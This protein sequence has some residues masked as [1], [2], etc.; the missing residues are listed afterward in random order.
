[1]L[2]LERNQ[3]LITDL[4]EHKST[5]F[6]LCNDRQLS[7]IRL[8]KTSV[9]RQLDHPDFW[10]LRPSN[11]WVSTLIAR[12]WW[13]YLWTK[14]KNFSLANIW[15]LMRTTGMEYF[16]MRGSWENPDPWSQH[17]E[18]STQSLSIWG[19]GYQQRACCL[20]VHF[21]TTQYFVITPWTHLEFTV[22][23]KWNLLQS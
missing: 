6:L 18:V 9:P 1:M 15:I 23:I 3:C 2:T 16:K 22:I 19:I 20:G 12:G 4:G 11:I 17:V 7:W 13:S 10:V 14:C 8:E 21:G 5:S